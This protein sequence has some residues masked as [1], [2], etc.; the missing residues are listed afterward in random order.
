MSP[1]KEQEVDMAYD[2]ST[3]QKQTIDSQIETNYPRAS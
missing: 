1:Y 2:V 3:V